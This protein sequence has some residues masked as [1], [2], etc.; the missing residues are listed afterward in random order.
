MGQR[1]RL[2]TPT[3]VKPPRLRALTEKTAKKYENK[4]YSMILLSL[5]PIN[6]G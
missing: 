3:P 2:V 1:D 5:Q 6:S 4:A